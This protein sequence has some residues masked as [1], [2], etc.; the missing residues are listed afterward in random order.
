MKKSILKILLA[1]L[2]APLFTSCFS[3]KTTEGVNPIAE[4]VVTGIKEVYNIGKNETLRITPVITQTNGGK[5]ITYYN[6]EMNLESKSSE[7]EFEFVG[8]D[9]GK[10]NCRFIVGNEDGK[11]YVP[12]TLYVNSPY[13]EG[14]T[15]LSKDK[16]GHSMISFMQ[17]PLEPGDVSK[18]VDGDCFTINNPNELFA[19]YPTDIVQSSGK[20]VVSCKGKGEG[21]DVPSIYYM[22]EK[23]FTLENH[24]TEP[25]YSD[26]VPTVLGVLANTNQGSSYPILCENGKVYEFSPSEGT[27]APPRMLQSEYEQKCV[28]YS[29]SYPNIIF[30][31]KNVNNPVLIYN[32]NGP[33]YCSTKYH[34]TLQDCKDGLAFYN[35]FFDEYEFVTMERIHLPV[36]K[37]NEEPQYIIITKSDALYH[38]VIMATSFWL[39]NWDIEQNY[40][41]YNGVP[42]TVGI[43]SPINDKTPC[44]A[45]GIYNSM[46]FADGNKV[47]CW[48]YMTSQHIMEAAEICKVGGNDAVIT[49][50]ALSP[51]N[52]RTYVAF[53]EPSKEGLNGSMWVIDSDTG[54]VLEKFEGIS[55]D[56]VKM[57]YKQR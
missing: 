35:K 31:D 13:E 14:I 6:W 48:Y 52:Q 45:N 29:G 25:K 4:I 57:I 55:Y 34:A 49:A 10:Y 22:D 30:W 3:D 11:T 36:G 42:K 38:S 54:E 17:V 5:P 24:L 44:V 40:L 27:V 8:N 53:T 41:S 1:L 39:Y 43:I 33:Y 9:L 19:S 56:A 23:T 16:D 15:I 18:F 47:R 50:F 21:Y 46:L 12:F 28:M 26:F 2:A 32:Y 37:T 51:D 7:P 20:L